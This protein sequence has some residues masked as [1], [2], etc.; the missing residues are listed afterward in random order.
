MRFGLLGQMVVVTEAGMAPVSGSHVGGM[1]A[2]LLL[3]PNTIVPHAELAADLWCKPPASA[4]DNLRKFAMRLR[5][6]LT[7]AHPGLGERL[8]TF[9]GGGYALRVAPGEVDLAQFKHEWDRGRAATAAGRFQEAT[10]HLV[11]ATAAWRGPAGLGTPTEGRLAAR[12]DV[13]NQQSL[14]AEE[15]LAA[16]RIGTGDSIEVIDDLTARLIMWPTRERAAQLLMIAYYRAGDVSGSLATYRSTRTR[17]VEELGVE[18][19]EC[20]RLL[21]RAALERDDATL[22]DNRYLLRNPRVGAIA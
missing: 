21:H 15:D 1:L 14:A 11:R 22:H 9:R 16:A 18:P 6:Q 5:R 2:S 10:T 3:R 17:S 4:E 19:G 20:L 13:L 7:A 12:L 8:T